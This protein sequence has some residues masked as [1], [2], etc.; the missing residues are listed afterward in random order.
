MSSTV[1]QV[2]NIYTTGDKALQK[3]NSNVLGKDDFLKLLVTQLKYQDPLK[4]MEDREF[5]AQTAQFSSLEQMQNINQ[6]FA[7]FLQMQSISN[8]ASLINREVSYLIP[9]TET[10]EAKVETGKVIEIKFVDGGTYMTIEGEGDVED[11][12]VPLDFL[13]SIKQSSSDLGEQTE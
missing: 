3:K 13:V 2:N 7:L 6:N 12:D 4:P 1:N 11:F 10:D 8:S 9:A 5:I